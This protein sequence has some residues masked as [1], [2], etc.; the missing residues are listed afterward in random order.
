M[1][2]PAISLI[3]RLD[4]PSFL[5]ILSLKAMSV[6][7]KSVRYTVDLHISKYIYFKIMPN[8]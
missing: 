2:N 4:L 5:D 3:L 7:S 6:T 1:D 8:N